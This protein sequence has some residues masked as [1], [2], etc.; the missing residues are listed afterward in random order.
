MSDLPQESGSTPEAILPLELCRVLPA[1]DSAGLVLAGG[2]KRFIIFIG[3]VEAAAVLR[4]LRKESSVRPLTHDLLAWIL[5]GFDIAVESVVISSV[6]NGAFC[7]TLTLVR[8]VDGASERVRLDAR[9]S[10]AIVLALRH[11]VPL[12]I[13]R[14]V[15]DE[16]EDVTKMLA[17]L[18]EQLDKQAQS[19]G[20]ESPESGSEDVPPLL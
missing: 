11:A 5:A 4:E 15:V 7:S 3:P 12:Q 1:R 17:E 16:V 6:V 10:D 20:E 8:S 13:T 2:G 9:A 14:R 19:E 18:E